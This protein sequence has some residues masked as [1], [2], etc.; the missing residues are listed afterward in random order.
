M[1]T[2]RRLVVVLGAMGLACVACDGGG[3]SSDA[4]TESGG[5][6]VIQGTERVRAESLDTC[7]GCHVVL[8]EVRAGEAADHIVPDL[9]RYLT[10]AEMMLAYDLDAP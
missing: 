8:D 10:H 3:G 5:P 9:R 2:F 7:G 4:G 1:R 6:I